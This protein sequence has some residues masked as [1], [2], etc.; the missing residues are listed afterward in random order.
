M[1]QEA[2]AAGLPA[3]GSRLNA[4]PEIVDDEVTGILV[5]P[6]HA[7]ELTAAL[8]R[9]I[10]S[11]ELRERLGRAARQKIEHDADPGVHRER[12]VALIK[13]VSGYG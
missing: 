12:L 1:Y 8:D 2:A 5:T 4:V 9:L 10:S 3:I 11:A 13:Q 6:G 7:G